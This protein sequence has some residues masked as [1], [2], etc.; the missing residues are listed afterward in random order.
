MTTRL[1]PTP[2]TVHLP[3]SGTFP[4]VGKIRLGTAT[5]TG[6][7]DRFGQEKVRPEKADHFI[8]TADE[9]GI[10][11][12]AAAAAFRAVYGDEPRT[13]RCLLLAPEPEQNMTGAWRLYGKNKLK[14]RCDG[15][16]CSTR[17]A[18]GWTDAPCQ[19][20]AQGLADTDDQHCTLTYTLQVVLPDVEGIGVWQLD[21][22][23]DITSRRMADWLTMM[24]LLRGSLAMVEFDLHLV[25][26]KVNPVVNGREL[27]TTVYVLQPEATGE[28]PRAAIEQAQQRTQL[29]AAE[30]LP[31][32]PPIAADEEPEATLDHSG[33]D[34]DSP[35]APTNGTAETPS[36]VP[37]G[38]EV[39][40]IKAGLALLD[41]ASVEIV[42]QGAL[43]AGHAAT[44]RQVCAWLDERFGERATTDLPGCVADL[45]LET[46]PVTDAQEAHP[47]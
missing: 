40:P 1:G 45:R 6:K 24:R 21:S 2:Y 11:S 20:R 42:R 36:P 22:G 44:V 47:F 12:E 30:P 32:L 25:P 9:S 18:T 37:A 19:C 29:A 33:F 39:D 10:T 43:A 27:A 28:T 16:N 34:E 14:T 23:S 46:E 8:V 35:P 4:R 31:A 38:G 3:T 13:L 7:K 17:T 15:E 41:D 26:V 5:P